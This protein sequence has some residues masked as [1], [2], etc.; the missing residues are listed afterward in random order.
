MTPGPYNPSV[1]AIMRRKPEYTMRPRRTPIASEWS[2]S[3]G[4]VYDPNFFNR[5]SSPAFTFGGGRARNAPTPKNLKSNRMSKSEPK[6]VHMPQKTKAVTLSD[7]NK[8]FGGRKTAMDHMRQ[9]MMDTKLAQGAAMRSR[10]WKR[11][12]SNEALEAALKG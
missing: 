8:A 9:V 3:P 7:L 1:D 4:P 2:S 11:I 12:R 5:R 6:R 10:I